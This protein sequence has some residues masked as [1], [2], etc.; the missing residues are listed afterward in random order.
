MARKKETK[1]LYYANFEDIPLDIFLTRNM[2][3]LMA[4]LKELRKVNA[5]KE[6]EKA[7]SLNSNEQAKSIALGEENL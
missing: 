2:S 7:Q 3:A 6:K 1:R 5:Q 4:F